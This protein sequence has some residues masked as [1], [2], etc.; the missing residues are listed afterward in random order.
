MVYEHLLRCF[1]PE[2]PSSRF[3]KLFQVVVVIVLG[4]IL[5]LV[6][7][8]LGVDKLLA[9]AKDI[10][11]LCPITIAEVFLQLFISHFIVL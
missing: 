10:G 9:M 1:I 11:G 8:V 3:L 5:R 7:L 6:A 2:D 4:H